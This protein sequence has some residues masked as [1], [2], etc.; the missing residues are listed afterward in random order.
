MLININFFCLPPLRLLVKTP[1]TA[2]ALS[3][4][5]GKKLGMAFGEL[6]YLN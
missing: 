6:H 4:D 1:T 5:C 3:Y 2:A